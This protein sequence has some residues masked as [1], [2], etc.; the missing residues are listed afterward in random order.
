MAI[1]DPFRK[2]KL[3]DGETK[4]AGRLIS[5]KAVGL[6][7][8]FLANFT[9]TYTEGF[10]LDTAITPDFIQ[11]T[12]ATIPKKMKYVG[13]DVS[14]WIANRS[15]ATDDYSWE[16]TNVTKSTTLAT[17]SSHEIIEKGLDG[18]TFI[19]GKDQVDEG[20]VLKF[21]VSEGIVGTAAGQAMNGQ[22]GFKRS[23]L[24]KSISLV[25]W[26]GKTE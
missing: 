25:N 10:C 16:L 4:V 24:I 8:I 21:N 22:I 23:T 2:K 18:W 13:V 17:I 11:E 20:D 19:F 3:K 12:I 9:K 7:N 26:L 5:R 1:K 14:V 6:V 15:G